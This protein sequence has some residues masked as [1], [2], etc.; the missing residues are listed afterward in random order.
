MGPKPATTGDT[1]QH[2]YEGIQ[3]RAK[4]LIAQTSSTPPHPASSNSLQTTPSPILKAQLSA[5]PK[6]TP[7]TA[8][9]ST[10]VSIK[11]VHENQL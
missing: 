8:P 1:T 4:P 9:Q 2:V 7:T 11:I 6:P 5:P 3:V 10:K